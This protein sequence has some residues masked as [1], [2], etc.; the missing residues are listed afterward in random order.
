MPIEIHEELSEEDKTRINLQNEV[1]NHLLGEA[2]W[3]LDAGAHELVDTAKISFYDTLEKFMRS[4][5]A[6]T[7]KINGETLA[8]LLEYKDSD[9]KDKNILKKIIEHFKSIAY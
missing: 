8:R 1:G 3:T 7:E 9:W 5:Y 6:P 4:N 2:K